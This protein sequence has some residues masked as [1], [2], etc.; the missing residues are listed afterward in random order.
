MI[1]F[2]LPVGYLGTKKLNDL[3]KTHKGSQKPNP[4]LSSP[5]SSL[6]YKTTSAK[7]QNI[8]GTL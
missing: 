1:T 2:I 6:S 4:G 8:L 3:P 7:D 5:A